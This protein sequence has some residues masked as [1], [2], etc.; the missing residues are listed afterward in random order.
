MYAVLQGIDNQSVIQYVIQYIY[1]KLN[2][3]VCRRSGTGILQK[4]PDK[5]QPLCGYYSS[6]CAI[7]LD[8]LRHLPQI[9]F[10]IVCELELRWSIDQFLTAYAVK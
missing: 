1:R 4:L 3:S 2:I 6:L 8:L 10:G 5:K 7:G 9:A